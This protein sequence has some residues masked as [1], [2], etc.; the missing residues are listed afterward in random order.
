MKCTES[1]LN[2]AK[3]LGI[4]FSYNKKIENDQNFL[5]QIISIEKVI[6]L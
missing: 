2:T 6:K 5:K 4:P 1:G 3:T